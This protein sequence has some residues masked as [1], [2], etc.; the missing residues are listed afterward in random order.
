MHAPFHAPKEYIDKFKGAF[1]EGYDVYR[2]MVFA[3]QKEMGLIPEDAVLT[4]MNDRML[5]WDSLNDWEKKV[6]ARY[7]EVFAG[8]LNYTDTQLGRLLDYLK[9]I[10]QYD[11]TLIV[12]LSDNGASAEGEFYGCYS[13][14]YPI[15]KG[16]CAGILSE[17]EFEK[18]GSPESYCI[19]PTGWAWRATHR[20][21]GINPG[22]M[23]AAS[24]CLVL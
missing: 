22:C 9:K 5:P 24:R 19:Y 12:L 15:F 7:M 1:D 21:S 4:E 18:I 17:E 20:F 3:R 16:E 14:Q 23:A 8:F 11:N 6:F 10:G 2:Q 13:E